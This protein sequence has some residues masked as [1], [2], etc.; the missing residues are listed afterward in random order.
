MSGCFHHIASRV[1]AAAILLS[2]ASGVLVPRAAIAGTDRATAV[3]AVT[4]WQGPAAAATDREC[5]GENED[6]PFM[7]GARTDADCK[8]AT[9]QCRSQGCS[10]DYLHSP[11]HRNGPALS[12]NVGGSL[13]ASHWIDISL[14][15][16]PPPPKP[17]FT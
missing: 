10:G 12:R 16:I 14:R 5:T 8:L 6:H 7:A 11:Q 13:P 1:I 9:R 2:F 15:R 4:G 3:T 17:G